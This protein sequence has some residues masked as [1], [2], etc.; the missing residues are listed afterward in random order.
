MDLQCVCNSLFSSHTTPE[1]KSKFFNSSQINSASIVGEQS[2]DI[3]IMTE[4]D[5]KVTLSSDSQYEASLTTYNSKAITNTTYTESKG[6]LFSFG[7]SRQLNLAVEGDLND[8]EKKEIK[9]VLKAIFKMMKGLFFGKTDQITDNTRN[10][11]NLDTISKLEAEFE[12]KKSV[13]LV[14]QSTAK[15]ETYLPVHKNP[16]NSEIEL[17]ESEDGREPVS[18]VTDRMV[19]FVKDSDIKPEKLLKYVDRMFSKL[20]RALLREGPVGRK[21]MGLAHTIMAEFLPKLDRMSTES[22]DNRFQDTGEAEKTGI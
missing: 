5:D 6:R 21:R 16:N 1:T 2:A 10:I 7:A 18:R 17:T 20:S 19:Q 9:K 15:S 14:S 11:S 8:Q 3:T 12:F 22:E 4:E 13:T